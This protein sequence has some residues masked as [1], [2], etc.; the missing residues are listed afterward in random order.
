M[1]GGGEGHEAGHKAVWQQ[2]IKMKGEPLDKKEISLSTERKE[3][4]KLFERTV[5]ELG[6]KGSLLKG[7]RRGQ[8]EG[9]RELGIVS[10]QQP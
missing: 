10:P 6:R 9:G 1:S 8:G 5:G 2:E 4:E 3:K 7:G